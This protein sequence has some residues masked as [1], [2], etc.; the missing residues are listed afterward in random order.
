MTNAVALHLN[1]V[2]AQKIVTRLFTALLP[3]AIAV[4]IGVIGT[5]SSIGWIAVIV[6]V[7][8]ALMTTFA[9]ARWRR[10]A[11][12]LLA[13]LPFTGI[14]SL[15]LYPKTF[16]GDV[17]R[18]FLIV[19]P[20]YLSLLIARGR[21]ASAPRSVII[22]I[23][24]MSLLAVLQFF[25]PSLPSALVGLVGLRGWL[26]F[27]PLIAVGVRLAPD[28]HAARRALLVALLAGLP[29]LVIGLVEAL[30][31]AAGKGAVLY[32]LYGNSAR[33]AFTTGDSTVQ[34]ASV[35]LGSLHRV[36][37]LFSY[38]AAYY[39]FCLAMLV[40]G[41]FLWQRGEARVIR[42]LG[43]A[44]FVLAVACALTSGTREAFITVPLAVVVTLYL[45]GVRPSLRTTTAGAVGFLA[46]ITLLHLPVLNL[47]GHLLDLSTHE[48]RDI[49]GHGFHVAR[50]VTW[51]G[52]GPGTDTNAARNVA[53]PQVFDPIGGRWQESYLVKSW[54]ELGVPGLLL[55]VWTLVA[56]VRNVSRRA[57]PTG[58][59]RSLV[60][61]VSGFLIAALATS[62]KG[63]ILDQAP[64]N[65]YFWLF[66][67][68]AI[69]AHSWSAREATSPV[70][71][72]KRA[73]TGSSLRPVGV[74]FGSARG[75]AR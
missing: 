38:P 20:L 11:I 39:C 24:L 72:G 63:A 7:V 34:G 54:I 50:S 12:F 16:L 67:G 55:V 9:V 69:G 10:V 41:Y 53:G 73:G 17:A 75:I 33:G 37:S 18:D 40:P 32:R 27:I 60:A 25:N 14:L 21:T 6:I 44:A 46:A 5:R 4:A 47:P 22:P 57:V 52:L 58:P 35:S 2:R 8:F 1:A 3:G 61:A 43:L 74:E 65:V 23:G 26:F 42:R 66:A 56:L 13:Y 28:V 36:P 15:L 59:G 48:S 45:D 70:T 30:A 49:L 64:A 31:L 19:T 62:I 29:V 71:A 68:L 51:L